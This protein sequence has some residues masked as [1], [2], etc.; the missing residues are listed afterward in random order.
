MRIGRFGALGIED[1]EGDIDPAPHEIPSGSETVAAVVAGAA[2]NEDFLRI[3]VA[4]DY[5]LCGF[6][7][8]NFHQFAAAIGNFF[9]FGCF[10]AAHVV[11]RNAIIAV[12]V[13]RRVPLKS[14]YFPG[15]AVRCQRSA[16][17]NARRLK[18]PV[19]C[20]LSAIGNALSI[21]L[22]AP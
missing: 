17:G 16:V 1:E 18:A 13:A 8:R 4:M 5:G 9:D 6:A 3:G 10:Q 22:H 2:K 7:A 11:G 14:H 21:L 12:D 15:D 20:R 19:R